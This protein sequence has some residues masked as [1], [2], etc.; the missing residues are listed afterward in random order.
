MILARRLAST[1]IEVSNLAAWREFA[2]S[3]L[4]AQVVDGPDGLVFLRVDERPYRIALRQ[5]PADDIRVLGLE[6]ESKEG[7]GRVVSALKV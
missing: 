2:S 1:T 6:V 7:L 5:G 3:I 4:C